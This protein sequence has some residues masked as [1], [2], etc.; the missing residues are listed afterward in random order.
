MASHHSR[1]V[2]IP[3]LRQNPKS[4]V[5][6]EP[7]AIRYSACVGGKGVPATLPVG[8]VPALNSIIV[9]IEKLRDL[10]A[11][12]AVINE[13]DGIGPACNPVILTLRAHARDKLTSLWGGK[14]TGTYHAIT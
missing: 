6:D 4:L 11:A 12:F 1:C 14:K 10:D 3:S 13:Q 8:L 5:S 7:E 2:V 9:Q